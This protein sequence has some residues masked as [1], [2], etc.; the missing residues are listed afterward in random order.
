MW[1]ELF[2]IVPRPLAL[3]VF[4]YGALSWFVTGPIVAERTAE[5]RYY[6]ACLAGLKAQPLP[7][8]A[9]EELL[10]ELR[11]SP[12]LQDPLMRSLGIDRYLDLAKPRNQAGRKTA[13]PDP[14]AKCRCLI[15]QAIAR[16]QTAWALY[17]GSLRLIARP[18]VIRFDGLITRI[19]NEGVCHE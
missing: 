12:L 11:K 6:P 5:A 8:N 2:D 19:A 7:K 15:D 4:S 14:A 3:A 16:S 13:M 1:K 10:D 18:E 17:A 9:G